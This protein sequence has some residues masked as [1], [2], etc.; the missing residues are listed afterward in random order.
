MTPLEQFKDFL[1]RHKG[2]LHVNQVGKAV[3]WVDAWAREYI[4]TS[5]EMAE[6]RRLIIDAYN[7]K[8]EAELRYHFEMGQMRLHR[9]YDDDFS[10]L[11]PK[12]GLLRT[13]L[14]YTTNTESPT[15]YHAFSF[16]TVLGA[17]LQRQCYVEQHAAGRIWP[18]L[19]CLLVGPSGEGRKTTAAE[20]AMK[21][22]R[23]AEGAIS[24][25][26][27]DADNRFCLIAE[28]GTSEAIHTALAER[29]LNNGSACGI[30][31]APEFS[32]FINKRDY[33][34]SLINDL[35][36]LWDCP[37]ELP[38]RTQSRSIEVLRNVAL[39]GLF[40]SNEEWLIESIPDDAFKGGF[41]ARMTQVYSTGTSKIFP[42]PPPLDMQMREQV[43]LGLTATARVAGEVTKTR[44]AQ[45]LY[46][47]IYFEMKANKPHDPRIVPFH[48]RMPE[49][50]LRCAM[51]LSICEGQAVRPF[52][53]ESHIADAKRI[54]DWV[55][56]YLPKVYALMGVGQV[57]REAQLII[58]EL[59]KNGGRMSRTALMRAL[60]KHFTARTF[61]EKVATLEQAGI[62]KAV[63]G[64]LFED[65]RDVVYY[66][67]MKRPEDI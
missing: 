41:F 60:Y 61:D 7:L 43:L 40:C 26:S 47:K 44:Q 13:Y 36:R 28:K 8:D 46:D 21:T 14:D 45:G 23:S 66:K 10:P 54:Y 42:T 32:T 18:N 57:G 63:V 20:F 29:S 59:L 65:T 24:L 2:R 67:L 6:L 34:K 49:H 1:L 39:S 58:H 4:K 55:L 12:K 5:E 37:D 52:I 64:G 19:V 33:T 3:D 30:L 22:A 16:L 51:L 35:T 62:V 25:A 15:A 50:I 31:Y 27:T 17:L 56:T 48:I 9:A 11:A 53:E 38:V